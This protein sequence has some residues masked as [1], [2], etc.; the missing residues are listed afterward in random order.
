MYKEVGGYLIKMRRLMNKDPW[1]RKRKECDELNW[2]QMIEDETFA[3]KDHFDD[4][5]P[6]ESGGL[7][8]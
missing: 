5:K 6:M 8:V 1:T 4:I 2:S 3:D 7:Q